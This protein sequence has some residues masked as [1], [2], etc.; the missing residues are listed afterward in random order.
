M[1]NVAFFTLG[2]CYLFI[3]ASVGIEAHKSLDTLRKLDR[4]VDGL[5]PVYEAMATV[6]EIV[7]PW[8]SP[9]YAEMAM[10]VMSVDFDSLAEPIRDMGSRCIDAFNPAAPE[11]PDYD[12]STVAADQPAAIAK[13]LGAFMYEMARPTHGPVNFFKSTAKH[14]NTA[15]SS[16]LHNFKETMADN[17]ETA[18]WEAMGK[19]CTAYATNLEQVDF[20]G[21][22]E[23]D[24]QSFDSWNDCYNRPCKWVM[25][26][27]E[28]SSKAKV[29]CTYGS[30][31]TDAD[32]KDAIGHIREFCMD[33]QTVL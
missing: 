11:Q 6:S 26:A 23:V 12:E 20:Y 27:C 8:G 33:L 28:Y 15:L 14:D 3:F 32:I 1:W 24:V 13:M 9:S 25:D 22:F 21:T 16:M 4:M 31:K 29:T 7:L 17:F 2:L 18:N 10:D 19:A 5:M 30:S